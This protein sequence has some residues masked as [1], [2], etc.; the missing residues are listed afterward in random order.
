[1]ATIATLHSVGFL[2]VQNLSI[3]LSAS[4]NAAAVWSVGGGVQIA[5][6]SPGGVWGAPVSFAPSGGASNVLAKLDAQGNGV[7]AWS[8]ID[9]NGV[10]G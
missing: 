6:R 3:S 8:P 1:M 2:V 9:V 4:N 5:L 7:A 10:G